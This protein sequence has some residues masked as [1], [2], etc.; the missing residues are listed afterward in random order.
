[1]HTP[2]VEHV[3]HPVVAVEHGEHADWFG[4]L[5]YWPVV[6]E[7]QAVASEFAPAVVPNLP[8]G[9]LPPQAAGAEACPATVPKRPRLHCELQAVTSVVEP[10]TVPNLPTAHSE[11]HANACDA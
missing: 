10:F 3:V 5:V 4:I 6:H 2:V 9:Q 8:A 1:M 7:E 11:G